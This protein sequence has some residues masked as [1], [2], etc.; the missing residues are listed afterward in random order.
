[1]GTAVGTGSRVSVARTFEDVEALRAALPPDLHAVVNNAGIVVPG[2]VEGVALDDLRN[3]L[4]VNVVGQV[5]VTQAV[6]PLLRASE[7]RTSSSPTRSVVSTRACLRRA[8]GILSSA[9]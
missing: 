5:A 4:E 2:P 6:L 7:G 9:W 3:Q 1:M 8:S